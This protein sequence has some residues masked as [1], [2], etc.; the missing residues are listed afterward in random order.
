MQ[1]QLLAVETYH[2]SLHRMEQKGRNFKKL[3][4]TFEKTLRH[5]KQKN[6]H[7]IYYLIK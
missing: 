2:S 6:M 7:Y 5:V 4:K 3:K 1:V